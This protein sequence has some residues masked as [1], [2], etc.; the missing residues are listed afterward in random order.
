MNRIESFNSNLVRNP[1][2][3]VKSSRDHLSALSRTSSQPILI[4]LARGA[5][6]FAAERVPWNLIDEPLTR[7]VA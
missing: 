2:N 1:V 7:Q 5:V 6:V 4:A 3:P